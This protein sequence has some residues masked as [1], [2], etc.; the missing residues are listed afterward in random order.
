MSRVCAVLG[1]AVAL[2]AS[3]TAVAWADDWW[4][5]VDCSQT[6]ASGCDL[7]VGG[8]GGNQAG[9]DSAVAASSIEDCEVGPSW[10]TAQALYEGQVGTWVWVYCPG[11]DARFPMFVPDGDAGSPL[12]TLA[13]QDVA[14]MARARLPLPE[15]SIVVNPAGDQLVGLP[16]WLWVASWEPVSATAS[17]AGVSVTAT[18][19]PVSVSWSM[20]DGS[21]VQCPGPGT[22]YRPGGDPSAASPDC[23]YVYSRSS[24][25]QPGLAFT[26]TATVR[27]SVWWSGAGASGTFA[28]LTTG[29]SRALRVAE[30]Q[31]VIRASG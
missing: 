20:G 26:A 1:G 18:A 6:P 17:V 22:A 30:S 3:S 7:V 27:W 29:G 5:D 8:F 23:G 14:V 11:D 13:P 16:T 15:P 4:G 31:A 25:R 12:P 10:V 21:T 24:A 9:G 19:R 28:D 2:L